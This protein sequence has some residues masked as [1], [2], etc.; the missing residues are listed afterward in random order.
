MYY[1]KIRRKRALHNKDMN[2]FFTFLNN[3]VP[4]FL[5]R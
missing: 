3:M 2:V 4:N 5:G 1:P